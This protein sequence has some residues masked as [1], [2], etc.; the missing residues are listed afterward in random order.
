MTFKSK[1][2]IPCPYLYEYSLNESEAH[3]H[4]QPPDE[5]EANADDALRVEAYEHDVF[6]TELVAERSEEDPAKHH[7]TKV[8]RC[9]KGSDELA[10]ADESPLKMYVKLCHEWDFYDLFLI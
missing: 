7:A 10:V 8:S 2:W 6:A 3:K 4:H 1:D 5:M 9:D